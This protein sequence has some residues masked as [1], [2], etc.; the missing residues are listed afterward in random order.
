MEKLIEIKKADK[1][2]FVGDAHGD[3]ETSQKVTWKR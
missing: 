1:I 2:I 3:S